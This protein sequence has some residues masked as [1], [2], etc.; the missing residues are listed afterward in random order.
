ML[1]LSFSD[2]STLF[3]FTFKAIL[4]S[5]LQEVHVKMSTIYF[6]FTVQDVLFVSPLPMNMFCISRDTK[7]QAQTVQ[8]IEPRL[9]KNEQ[10]SSQTCPQRFT[11]S[12]C[13]RRAWAAL[14][15][16][17]GPLAVRPLTP[18]T[19]ERTRRAQGV[20]GHRPAPPR[21]GQPLWGLRCGRS[22]PADDQGVGSTPA[23]HYWCTPRPSGEVFCTAPA[24]QGN[25]TLTI[26][27]C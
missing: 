2:N 12:R 19:G 26:T 15:R 13:S 3:S 16:S 8:C 9:T 18:R 27:F 24:G 4:Q 7:T 23:P 10:M 6:E 1:T 21:W 17:S 14:R 25:T 22:T 5:I 11:T 20:R